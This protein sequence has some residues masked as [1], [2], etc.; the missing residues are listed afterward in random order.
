MESDSSNCLGRKCADY[1]SCFYF[2]A[3]RGIRG[4]HLLV[5]NHALYFADLALRRAG[6]GFLPEYQVAILDEAHTVEDVAAAH[7]GLRVT[8]G[9]VEH[10]LTRLFHSR[11]AR[12]LLAFHGDNESL[13]QVERTRSASERFFEEIAAWRRQQPRGGGRIRSARSVPDPL[14]EE[15]RK[16]SGQLER[17]AHELNDEEEKIEVEAAAARCLGLAE[18]ITRW[19][20]QQLPGQVYWVEGEHDS[21]RLTLASAPV[22]VG[23]ALGRD[24]YSQVPTVV[25]T[26]ATLSTGGTGGFAHLRQRLGLEV[27]TEIQLGS[28]FNFREQV[29]LHLFRHMPDPSAQGEAFE[30]ACAIR[31]QEYVGR[32]SGR[33]FVL[34]TSYQAMQRAARELGP[35]FAAQGL[36]LLCQGEGLPR[37]HMVERFRSGARSVLFG[38]DSFWQGVDVQG[39]ALSNVI[40]TRLPF[41]APDRPVVEARMEGIEQAGGNAFFDYQVPQAVI[42]LKQGFGRLVRT[43][44]DRGMVVILDPRIL[45]K[46]YGR[47]FL[48]ALP[49]CRLFIDGQQVDGDGNRP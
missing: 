24:L 21:R 4:A 14:S 5:V 32:T 28:P 1:E 10:T 41:A 34:Y 43:Q 19:Q 2:R 26:S 8:R 42:K 33:A 6:A 40:I 16:L 38:V 39:E 49:E 23:P 45:T 25:L 9:A 7:L 31:I 17:L 48:Q 20:E 3:R 27:G 11:T 47:V 22:D 37:S 46:P 13:A 18:S 12:G 35:V 29:E 36:T 15:F 44:E 30:R